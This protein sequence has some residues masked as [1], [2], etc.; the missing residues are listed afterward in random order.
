MSLHR[1]VG[2]RPRGRAGRVSRPA[3]C[4]P[5]LAGVEPPT[6]TASAAADPTNG[7]RFSTPGG[8]SATSRGLP[9][10]H[11]VSGISRNPGTRPQEPTMTINPETVPSTWTTADETFF[12]VAFD[13]FSP[14]FLAGAGV[15][16]ASYDGEQ[17][18]ISIA[19]PAVTTTESSVDAPAPTVR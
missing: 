9:R 15:L 11:N 16:L 8:R 5:P 3:S 18:A 6:R 17:T 12:R 1:A 4:P 13:A 2:D 7:W 14:D 19:T 10:V